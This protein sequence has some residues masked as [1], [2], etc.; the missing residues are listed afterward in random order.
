MN[1]ASFVRVVAACIVPFLVE[2]NL[3]ENYFLRLGDNC[4]Y[5]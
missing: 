5:L 3:K 1:L 2:Q 4:K